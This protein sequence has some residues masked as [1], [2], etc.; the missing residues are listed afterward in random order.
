MRADASAARPFLH[1]VGRDR[2]IASPIDPQRQIRAV[3]FD[4]DGTLYDQRRLRRR[5]LR[6]LV[7]YCAAHPLQGPRA[8]RALAEYRKGQEALRSGEVGPNTQ[9]QWA[10]DRTGLSV[11][12][13]ARVVDEWM[14]TR[15]LK[16]LPTCRAPGTLELVE[17]L[18]RHDVEMGILSDY[19][20]MEKLRA[21]G[22]HERFSVVLC[23]TD[24]EV[25]ALKPHPRG[26][27]RAC[28][29]W[30]LDADEVLVVGDRVDA[31][32]A[33]AAAAGMPCVLVGAPID[34]HL[35]ADAL[36]LSSIERLHRVLA[37]HTR[38]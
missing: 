2:G 32:A 6:E 22:V 16:H 18:D 14:F 27:L 3:L 7:A 25:S 4:L 19:P 26:F 30:R 28:E 12:E 17:W 35:P 23:A 38:C 10:A 20:A 29:R 9:I 15:P 21:L 36:V 37:N 1:V 34:V 13:V 8:C 24:P 33:G 31:D 11:G 5:M